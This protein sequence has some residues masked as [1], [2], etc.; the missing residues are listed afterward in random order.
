MN[1]I[2]LDPYNEMQLEKIRIFEEEKGIDKLSKDILRIRNKSSQEEYCDS[3]K[4]EFEKIIFVEKDNKIT[5]CC[6]IYGE[7][8]IKQCRITPINSNKKREMTILA[9]EY[10]LNNLGMEEVFIP[11]DK[12][13]NSM[14]TYLELR[15]Y[16]NI[17]EVEGNILL[18]KEKKEKENSQ[19][20]V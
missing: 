18:L 5:D 14:I 7:K 17:G 19:R 3:N 9:T 16:E 1:I 4:N 20:M 12:D 6:Y 13:D 11:V 8:D 2:E 10:A 15:E